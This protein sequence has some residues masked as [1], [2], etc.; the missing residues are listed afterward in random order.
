MAFF[1]DP[2]RPQSAWGDDD[3]QGPKAASQEPEDEANEVPT[4]TTKEILAWA[5]DDKERA[6]RAL[7]AENE[8]DEPRKGLVKELNARLEK[9]DDEE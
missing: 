6:Q 3:N 7:D 9:D 4:G 1:H 8:N 2:Y 5:G